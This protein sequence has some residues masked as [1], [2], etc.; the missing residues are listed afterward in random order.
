MPPFV[1]TLVVLIGLSVAMVVLQWLATPEGRG[2]DGWANALQE[3]GHRRA[4]KALHVSSNLSILQGADQFCQHSLNEPRNSLMRYLRLEE[5][6]SPMALDVY[7]P[8]PREPV[9]TLYDTVMIIAAKAWALAMATVFIYLPLIIGAEMM[10]RDWGLLKLPVLTSAVVFAIAIAMFAR[11]GE[12]PD[13]KAGTA[14]GALSLLM[15]VVAAWWSPR[16]RWRGR[17]VISAAAL[18]ICSLIGMIGMTRGPVPPDALSYAVF[19]VMT[20]VPLLVGGGLFLLLVR[21]LVHLVGV[22]EGRRLQAAR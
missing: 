22:V 19:F 4:G 5:A 15:P 17:V 13:W 7:A 6:N 9:P 12:D 10:R 14:L 18:T 8:S 21:A 3:S 16:L 11:T 2:A 1:K 20:L